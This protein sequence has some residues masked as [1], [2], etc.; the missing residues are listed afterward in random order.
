MKRIILFVLIS[1]LSVILNNVKAQTVGYTYR[2]LA[3][4]GCTVNYSVAKQ[5]DKF[6]IIAT[7]Q[8]DRMIF[9]KESTMMVRT[10]NGDVMRFGGELIENGTETAGMIS[11]NMIL[12]ITSIVSSAQFEV[13]PEQFGLLR[14]GVIKVRLTTTPI[15]HER[16]FKKDKIG[17]K[18]YDFYLDLNK[19]PDDF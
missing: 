6:Y 8:S 3:D 18:L 10:T 12:P 14:D 4:E 2:P 1:T 11:G 13:F 5:N 19:I 15:Q 7:V 9:L 16:E 17:K